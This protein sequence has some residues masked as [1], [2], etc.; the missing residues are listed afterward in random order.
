MSFFAYGIYIY[1][2]IILVQ[3]ILECINKVGLKVLE[4][5]KD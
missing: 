5:F 4:L 2:Q 3:V 1:I